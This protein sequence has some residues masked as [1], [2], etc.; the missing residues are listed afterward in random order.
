LKTFLTQIGPVL[1]LTSD[2]PVICFWKW[3]GWKDYEVPKNCNLESVSAKNE[4]LFSPHPRIPT[5]LYPQPQRAHT[6]FRLG[7]DRPTLLRSNESPTRAMYLCDPS[8]LSILSP[9]TPAILPRRCAHTGEPPPQ[10]NSPAK[11]AAPAPRT[12]GGQAPRC[13]AASVGGCGKAV[14][15]VLGVLC[16]HRLGTCADPHGRAG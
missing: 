13:V 9:H 4:I 11:A 8:Y 3:I 5:L 2:P 1:P 14:L 15:H 16:R 10:F 12:L 7:G 6:S